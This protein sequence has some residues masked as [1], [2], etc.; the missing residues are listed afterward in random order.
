MMNLSQA[1]PRQLRA[2][3][4]PM[5]PPGVFMQHVPA[6]VSIDGRGSQVAGSC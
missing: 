1:P 5:L 3:P 4:V 6:Q 2:A